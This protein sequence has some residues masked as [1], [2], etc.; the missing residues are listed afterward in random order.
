[1]SRS[2]F[3]LPIVILL[4]AQAV[5]FLV[6]GIRKKEIGRFSFKEFFG[7][8]PSL[9]KSNGAQLIGVGLVSVLIAVLV[10]LSYRNLI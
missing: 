9:E 10:F 6:A 5:V 2:F 8:F 3:F 4:S 1:M 7:G